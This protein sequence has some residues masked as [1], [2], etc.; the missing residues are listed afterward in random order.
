VD[1]DIHPRCTT[2][3]C[4]RTHRD[5][6]LTKNSN[7]QRQ[8]RWGM[9][10][11]GQREVRSQRE[12]A[13]RNAHRHGPGAAPSPDANQNSLIEAQRWFRTGNEIHQTGCNR[14]QGRHLASAAGATQQVGRH[15]TPLRLGNN[16][17]REL[18]GQLPDLDAGQ[19]GHI[20]PVL[21]IQ[22]FSH[23]EHTVN[24]PGEIA[25]GRAPKTSLR[26]RP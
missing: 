8:N 12:H 21:A 7:W 25:R 10:G 18:R 9:R 13:H 15:L 2:A 22:S 6:T 11:A 26:G 5:A 23:G 17:Q 20:S 4:K 24:R 1:V 19:V 3:G 14:V 16:S